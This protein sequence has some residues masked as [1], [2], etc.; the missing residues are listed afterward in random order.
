MLT[1]ATQLLTSLLDT[2]PRPHPVES[3]TYRYGM[4]IIRWKTDR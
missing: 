1:L 3:I 2:E 4:I